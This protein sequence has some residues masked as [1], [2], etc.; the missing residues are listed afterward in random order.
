MLAFR[1]DPAMIEKKNHLPDF[2]A[3]SRTQ[4]LSIRCVALMLPCER[5][6]VESIVC[7]LAEVRPTLPLWLQYLLQTTLLQLSERTSDD[8]PLAV[9]SSVTIKSV[10]AASLP[11]VATN[12]RCALR[13]S[14]V[15]R[16]GKAPTCDQQLRRRVVSQ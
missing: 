11:R 12:A 6:S 14:A 7:L 9:R 13:S 10:R 3:T 5:K 15:T 2:R 16:G 8:L 1:C 4:G